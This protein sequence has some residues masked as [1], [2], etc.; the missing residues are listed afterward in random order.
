MADF[1]SLSIKEIKRITPNAVTLT[2]DIPEAL[3]SDFQFKAGQYITIKKELDGTELRRAYSVCVAPEKGA[4]QVGIKK[5]LNGTFSRYANNDLSAGDVL[6]VHPPEGRFTFLPDASKKRNIAA[7]AAGSGITPVMSIMHTV[8]RD[9]PE[10]TFALVY[11]NKSLTETM[12]YEDI[13]E[14]VKQY[15][16]RLNVHFIYSQSQEP[17]CLFGRI[18]RSTV[19]FILKNKHKGEQFDAYYLCGPEAMIDTVTETLTDNG[20]AKDTIKFELFTAPEDENAAVSVEEGKVQLT[21]L[22]DDE[23]TSFVMNKK[24]R[25][26]DAVLKK[27]IDAPYSCQGGVCSSCIARVTKGK[28]EMVQNQILTDSEIE[29]GLILTCQ[30]HA[31]T[32]TLAIDYDDV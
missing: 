16:N 32:D 21:V 6:E 9:E 15:P 17:E 24:E 1:H 3:Q 22:V 31:V 27:D 18:E 25:I 8:L 26:L 13:L 28:A 19:N 11:G 10:S 4:L 2:F 23:E 20:I 14:L 7:F 5:T 30:A 29:E 12:F